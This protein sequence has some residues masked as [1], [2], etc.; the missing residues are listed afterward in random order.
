MLS[1]T[2]TCSGEH[3]SEGDPSENALLGSK[4][5]N[6]EIIHPHCLYYVNVAGVMICNY[7]AI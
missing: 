3:S 6:T 1:R 4:P 5:Q 7:I 2:A